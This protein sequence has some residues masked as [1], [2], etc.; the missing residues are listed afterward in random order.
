MN[1]IILPLHTNYLNYRMKSV[2]KRY[3]G[4]YPTSPHKLRHTSAALVKQAEILLK[5]ILETLTHSNKEV[6]KT[7]V[8]TI[9]KVNKAVG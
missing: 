4:L 9:Y 7:Y 3:S 2:R 8:N 6:I 5:T 1:N